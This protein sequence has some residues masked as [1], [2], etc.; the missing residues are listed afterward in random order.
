MINF[1]HASKAPW[2]SLPI[3]LSSTAWDYLCMSGTVSKCRRFSFIFSLGNKRKSQGT[4]SGEKGGW[5]TITMLL[6][7]TNPVVFRDMWA[8]ML[9]WWRSQMWL[10]H[11]FT[12]ESQSITIQVRVYYSTRRN[13]SG[14]TLLFMP[15][16]TMSM[17]LV[18][19]RTCCS[20][21]AWWLWALP[22]CQMLLC[23]WIIT[24]IELPPHVMIPEIKAGSLL[25]FSHSSRHVYAPLLLIVCQEL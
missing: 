22:L 4:T 15:K 14:W 20:F 10:S 25:V 17:L 3:M 16:K 23:F 13:N 11:I 8:G 12:Q 1:F 5:G 7:I 21:F 18:E 19:L 9:S 2:K 24:I 6:L